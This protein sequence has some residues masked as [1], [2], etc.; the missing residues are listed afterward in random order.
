MAALIWGASEASADGFKV[1]DIRLEVGGGS[2]NFNSEE[3]VTVTM[4]RGT[5]GVDQFPVYIYGQQLDAGISMLGQ[6][7]A[8]GKMRSFG[9]GVEQYITGNLSI[10]IEA[11]YLDNSW[12]SNQNIVQ[13]V[14]YTQLV[15][16]HYV[17][18]TRFPPIYSEQNGRSDGYT[19]EWE[20]ETDWEFRV[21][22]RYDITDYGFAS[23]SYRSARGDEYYRFFDEQWTDKHGHSWWEESK[24]R[25]LGGVEFNIGVRF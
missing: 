17:D 12:D 20:I 6:E 11:G 23:F 1:R 25:D 19:A 3:M 5:I 24:E 4:M 15:G 18:E 14:V 2:G 10:F 7:L 8:D 9:L 22:I 16:T 21:G 13:E